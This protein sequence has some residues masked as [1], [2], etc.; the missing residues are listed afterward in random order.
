[1]KD[2]FAHVTRRHNE[3]GSRLI[4]QLSVAIL[5]QTRLMK[6]VTKINCISFA[7]YLGESNTLDQQIDGVA[8]YY[9][10]LPTMSLL[11]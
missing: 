5:Q 11:F 10:P 7:P 3:S 4:E 9:D 8:D 1:M 6:V 2:G